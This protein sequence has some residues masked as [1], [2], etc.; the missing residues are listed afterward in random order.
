M[1]RDGVSAYAHYV[2]FEI[3]PEPEGYPLK[4]LKGFS[5]DAGNSLEAHLGSKFSTKDFDQDESASNC[6]ELYGLCSYIFN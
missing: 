1:D 3:G 6:A 2:V 4:S 5:G